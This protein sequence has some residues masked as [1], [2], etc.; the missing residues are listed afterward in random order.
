MSAR[1]LTAAVL[2]AVVACACEDDG[3]GPDGPGSD[4]F[5]WSGRVEPG[6]RLEIKGIIGGITAS[7][8]ATG[9]ALVTATK[10]GGADSPSTVEIEVVDHDEGVTLCAVYPDVSGQPPNECGPGTGGNLN[11][12]G[13]DVEVSFTVTVPTG[14]EFV[15]GT[16]TGSVQATGLRSDAFVSS[17]TGSVS[18]STTGIAEAS[19]VTGSVDASLGATDWGRDLT[20]ATVTGGVDVEI[21]AASNAQVDASVV[22]GTVTSDFPLTQAS[23][24]RFEGTIGTGGPTLTL[25]TVTGSVRLRRG[26]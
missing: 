15:G 12:H 22:T 10:I 4:V 25:S 8:S 9:I 23:P 6:D 14:V 11:N 16:V 5:E 21:P 24:G 7:R 2:A 3:T 18:V 20:F 13:N 17:V 19:S 1:T 26:P